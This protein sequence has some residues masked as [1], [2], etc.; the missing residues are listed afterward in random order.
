[1][2]GTYT[3]F[4]TLA[5]FKYIFFKNILVIRNRSV[6]LSRRAVQFIYYSRRVRVHVLDMNN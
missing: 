2:K 1:M 5:P 4:T 3:G 6:L